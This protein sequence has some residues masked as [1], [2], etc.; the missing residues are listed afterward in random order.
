MQMLERIVLTVSPV[1][2]PINM[3]GDMCLPAGTV[4]AQLLWMQTNAF[5]LYLRSASEE[6]AHTQY[7]MPG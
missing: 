5:L 6:G 2:Y 1:C 4:G 7:G 3:P